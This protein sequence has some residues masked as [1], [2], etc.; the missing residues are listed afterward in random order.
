VLSGQTL[1]PLFS[2]DTSGLENADLGRVVWL[3]GR[4]RLAAAGTFRPGQQKLAVVWGGEGRGPRQEFATGAMTTVMDL[5]T[6][7]QDLAFGS[8]DPAFGLLDADG[9]RVLFRGSPLADLRD[10]HREHFLVSSDGRRA[11]FGLKPSSQDPW[12]F[13]L[14]NL[15]FTAAPAAAFDLQAADIKGLAVTDWKDTTEPKLG[16]SAL[17]LAVY[18]R[19]RSLAIAPDAQSFILGTEWALRRFDK[20]GKQL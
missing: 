1:A 19:A 5:A 7:G 16:G 15:K 12:M 11:R 10:K 14:A 2:P 13:D 20:G 6:R 8:A 3:A 4:T 17:T 9:K 18:E